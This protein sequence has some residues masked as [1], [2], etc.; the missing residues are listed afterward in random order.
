MRFQ[1][2][3]LENGLEIVAECNAAAHSAA[4]GFFVETGA[5]DETDELAGVS[6][7]LEHMVFKGTPSRTA[8]D[9][10]RQFDEMGAHYN[11]FTS[12]ESTV[13]YAAVLPEQ[14]DQAIDLLSDIMRPSIRDE[15]FEMEKQVILEEIR[16][17]RRSASVWSR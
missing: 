1:R 7:F 11:A 12:E 9:V 17:V 13:F 10:N 15:D 5:R 16:D 14:Q 4:Y 6:H 8:D 2:K 3:Q